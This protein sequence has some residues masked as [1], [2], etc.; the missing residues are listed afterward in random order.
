MFQVS[1][2]TIQYIH[3]KIHFTFDILKKK[4]KKILIE[5][6]L[7]REKKHHF[8]TISVT[9]KLRY[10]TELK[11]RRKLEGCDISYGLRR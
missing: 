1:F 6:S 10:H 8:L 2:L 3:S 9:R 5:I 7:R 11:E 4:R